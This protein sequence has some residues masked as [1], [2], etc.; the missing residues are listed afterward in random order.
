MAGPF[1]PEDELVRTDPELDRRLHEAFV[2]RFLEA[3]DLGEEI[4][5]KVGS[6]FFLAKGDPDLVVGPGAP[7]TIPADLTCFFEAT[8][9]GNF[10]YGDTGDAEALDTWIELAVTVA[11]ANYEEEVARGWDFP[12]LKLPDGPDRR[13]SPPAG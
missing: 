3:T 11:V 2:A 12:S 10:F 8:G 9:T 5:S 6:M 7:D 1:P 13:S 4:R